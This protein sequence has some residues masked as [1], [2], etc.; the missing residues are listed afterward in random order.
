[1]GHSQPGLAADDLPAAKGPKAIQF[2]DSMRAQGAGMD[3]EE[4]LKQAISRGK[5]RAETER[6][7]GQNRKLSEEELRRHHT[8]YRLALSEHIEDGLRKLTNHFPGFDYETVYGERGWGGAIKRDDL[9]KGGSFYSRLELVVRP[10]NQFQVV[11]ISGKGT[12]KNREVASWNHFQEIEQVD[13]AEFKT[14][15][16]NWILNYAELFAA[17]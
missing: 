1:M 4:Q 16:D 14:R 10:L 15:I 12:I 8:D 3:F 7:A 9:M 6:A 2:R 11:N 5:E 17:R 13:L